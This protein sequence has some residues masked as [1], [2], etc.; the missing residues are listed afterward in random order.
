VLL[1]VAVTLIIMGSVFGL[2]TGGQDSFGREN[3]VADMQMSTRAGLDM[4]SRDL[5]MAGF[6]TPPASAILWNDG[7]GI[8]PDE[9][10]L[11]YADPNVPISKPLQCGT[12]GV[13]GGGGACGTIGQSATLNIDVATLDP[14]P[15]VPES[16]YSQ[17]M[18]LSAIETEDC[19]GD[20]QVGIVP[21]QVTDPPTVTYANGQ[22]TLNVNHNPG[23]LA[24]ELNP[25]GGFNGEV[26]E[27]CAV[28]GMFRVI[29]YRVSPPPPVGNP[30]LER[31]D[32][33]EGP[34]WLTVAHNIENLQVRY[35]IGT[36]DALLDAPMA[37][38]LDDPLTWINRVNITL[39]G[40]SESRNL[41]GASA[42]VFDPADT[43][44]RMTFSS[45]VSLRNVAAQADNR[46]ALLP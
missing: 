16:A 22:P 46:V 20:G 17:G 10:T 42:G 4:M 18:V 24:T 43:Y 41:K 30:T 35:G 2:L 29:T 7:G 9:V 13:G 33:T 38:P 3:E 21:F 26:R 1:A 6:R 45:M 40:R 27:D 23:N 14:A 34:A 36:G 12:A 28:V 31:R 44:L 37:T 25:P 8:Q 11:V 19:N 15:S 32:L 39:T 5:T